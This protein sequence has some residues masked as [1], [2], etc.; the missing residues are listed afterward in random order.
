V[1]FTIAGHY[2]EGG[3]AHRRDSA[4]EAIQKAAEMECMGMTGV[5]ITD[6]ATGRAYCHGE[7]PLLLI[8]NVEGALPAERAIKSAD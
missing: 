5:C 1:P 8:L 3:I 2:A 6:T 4:V 7:F